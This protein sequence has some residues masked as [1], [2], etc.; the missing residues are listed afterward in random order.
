MNYPGYAA[1]I[2]SVQ[3]PQSRQAAL[4]G[5]SSHFPFKGSRMVAKW[6]RASGFVLLAVALAVPQVAL[7]ACECKST[8]SDADTCCCS[9]GSEPRN[10]RA[11][12]CCRTHAQVQ[13]TGVARTRCD[14]GHKQV[15]SDLVPAGRR[16]AS[17]I[18]SRALSLA[19]RSLAC[20]DHGQSGRATSVRLNHP[21]LQD[22]VSARI[23]YCVWLS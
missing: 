15:K 20:D 6:C 12:C 21:F 14:C 1:E 23:L 13:K 2:W 9:K 8:N 17:A 4:P 10:E 16:L 5:E 3:W 11:S 18:D 7:S 22:G 19:S